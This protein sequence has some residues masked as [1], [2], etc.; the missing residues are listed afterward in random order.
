MNV[1]KT[2]QHRAGLN[3]A[4]SKVYTSLAL[5]GALVLIGI[6]ASRLLVGYKGDY[7]DWLFVLLGCIVI[8]MLIGSPIAYFVGRKN[9]KL[10]RKELEEMIAV[11]QWMLPKYQG[12]LT[13]IQQKIQDFP[14]EWRRQIEAAWEQGEQKAKAICIRDIEEA[15]EF[16]REQNRQASPQYKVKNQELFLL[17]QQELRASEASLDQLKNSVVSQI[18]EE[19]LQRK[20]QSTEGSFNRAK[21]SFEEH[22][23]I[24]QKKVDESQ[25]TIAAAQE[26]LRSFVS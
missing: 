8:G 24:W 23:D 5:L 7:G 1:L 25:S 18:S 15:I 13:A 16:L 4:I 3:V 14:Q 20:F 21:R 26:A 12:F 17:L 11:E 19:M 22:R 6:F 2:A 10:I 9:Q